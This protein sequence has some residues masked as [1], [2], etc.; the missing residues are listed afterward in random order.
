MVLETDKYF[1]G[2]VRLPQCLKEFRL[3]TLKVSTFRPFSDLEASRSLLS[4]LHSGLQCLE[5]PFKGAAEVFFVDESKTS[6][7]ASDSDD[8]GVEFEPSPPKRPKLQ[9]GEVEEANGGKGPLNMGLLFPNLTSFTGHDR[10]SPST[11]ARLPRHLSSFSCWVIGNINDPASVEHFKALPP[12]LTSFS[13]EMQF[14]ATVLDILPSSL[15]YLSPD[16]LGMAEAVYLAK[17]P[18]ILPNLVEFPCVTSSFDHGLPSVLDRMLTLL[19]GR[20]PDNMSSVEAYD[21]APERIFAAL[22]KNVL[23][24]LTTGTSSP[25]HL[26]DQLIRTSLPKSLTT[27]K[28]GSINWDGVSSNIWPSTL[29]TLTIFN[30]SAA[31]PAQFHRLPRSLLYLTINVELSLQEPS[32]KGMTPEEEAQLFSLGQASLAGPEKESWSVAKQALLGRRI[33]PW[34]A[35]ED[36][37]AHVEKGGL[38]GLPL[39]LLELTLSCYAGNIPNEV[40]LPPHLHTLYLYYERP[41]IHSDNFFRLLP[42]SLTRT[43]VPSLAKPSTWKVFQADKDSS[44]AS[45]LRDSTRITDLSWMCKEDIS[46]YTAFLPRS[47]RTLDASSQ[48]TLSEAQLAD[49][50]PKLESLHVKL[51]AL[52]ADPGQWLSALP[53]GLLYLRVSMPHGTWFDGKYVQFLPPRLETLIFCVRNLTLAQFWSLPRTLCHVANDRPKRTMQALSRDDNTGICIFEV[54]TILG[55]FWK[56]RTAPDALAQLVLKRGKGLLKPIPR[57]KALYRPKMA[58]LLQLAAKPDSDS[59]D[60][61]DEESDEKR[62]QPPK[63]PKKRAAPSAP[64][65]RS[66]RIAGAEEK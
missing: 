10:W 16:A 11:F 26:T 54:K 40:L 36:Y 42:P 32:I 45:T 12:N 47:L 31:G 34:N 49:L 3:H 38:Y 55:A 22:S 44:I 63:V 5:L 33:D 1:R 20:L 57:T 58:D 43:I 9:E 2:E 39:G 51:K 29:I 8:A 64:P 46:P 48:Q 59:D 62:N 50:P 35:A 30:D 6:S 28:V 25:F 27:L 37:I 13:T 41:L 66:S 56:I 7:D 14:P 23:F 24:L 53:R 65:R 18:H 21:I 4:Q 17:N 15:T 19:G 61:D 52:P 60:D